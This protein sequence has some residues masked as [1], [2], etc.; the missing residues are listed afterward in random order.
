MCFVLSVEATARP[1]GLPMQ[2]K[3]ESE[4]SKP[5][6]DHAGGIFKTELIRYFDSEC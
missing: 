1:T 6:G 5:P 4:G 3:Q 2:L